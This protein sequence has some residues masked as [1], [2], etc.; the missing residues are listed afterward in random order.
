MKS[1]HRRMEG[2]LLNSVS[3][4]Q[5]ITSSEAIIILKGMRGQIDNG[6]R[7]KRNRH[8]SFI[9]TIQGMAYLLRVSDHFEKCE[10]GL[11]KKSL[12]RRIE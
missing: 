12:W 5:E 6:S 1:R 11:H 7:S 4:G 9:P 3:V 8:M 10:V 2:H